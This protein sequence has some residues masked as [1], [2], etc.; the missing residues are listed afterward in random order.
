VVVVVGAV[1]CWWRQPSYDT[2]VAVVAVVLVSTKALG[3]VKPKM[4][5]QC[6]RCEENA[7][8][9]GAWRRVTG[10]W[11]CFWFRGSTESIKKYGKPLTP[12]AAS[13]RTVP[14]RITNPP[15]DINLQEYEIIR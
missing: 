9:C 7:P 2:V 11:A 12:E 6:W 1:F 14:E 13:E 15:K 10:F 5:Q 8:P 3:V 4:D